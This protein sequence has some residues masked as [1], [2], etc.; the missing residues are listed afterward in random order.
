[1]RRINISDIVAYDADPHYASII[2]GLPGHPVE[3]VRI[4]NVRIVYQ[5]GGTTEDAA[6]E[7]PERESTY[8]EPSMFGTIP[9]YG[10]FVRHAKNVEMHHVEVSYENEDMRPALVLDDVDGA[11][12][13]AVKAR[14]GP[15]VPFFVLRG[16]RD[17]AVHNCE[18]VPDTRH[19]SVE[20]STY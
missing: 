1:M 4:S 12:F 18:G 2:A 6:I 10:F 11:D 20:K 17:F 8:P 3:D 7:P 13:H 9:A 14:R 19:D 16:V 15:D 5:G